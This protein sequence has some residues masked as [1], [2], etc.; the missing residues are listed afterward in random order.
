MLDD[1]VTSVSEV[2]PQCSTLGRIH[3]RGQLQ[4]RHPKTEDVARL[5]EPALQHLLSQVAWVT[6]LNT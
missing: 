1:D 2:M 4:Q 3:V 5:G 6:L